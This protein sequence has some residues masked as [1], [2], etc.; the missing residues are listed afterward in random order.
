VP[1]GSGDG[2]L[3]L[4][5]LVLLGV[6]LQLWMLVFAGLIALF[7]IYLWLTAPGRRSR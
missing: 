5:D 1:W 3:F 2:M 7:V 4:K 6:H